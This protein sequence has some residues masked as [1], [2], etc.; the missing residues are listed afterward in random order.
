MSK[1]RF[2]W[3]RFEW[4]DAKAEAT[5]K[6]HGV[7]FEEARSVF[8]DERGR[9]DPHHLG[10]QGDCARIQVLS[11]VGAPCARNTISPSPAR[12]PTPHG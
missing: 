6:K 11:V 7:T 10:A 12:I 1:V 8:F 3:V 2:E 4:D 9:P 5:A